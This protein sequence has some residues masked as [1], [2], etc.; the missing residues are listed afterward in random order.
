[1]ALLACSS[2]SPL[3]HQESPTPFR[4]CFGT[5][6]PSTGERLG[7]G[8]LLSLSLSL[9]KKPSNP[10]SLPSAGRLLAGSVDDLNFDPS[11]PVLRGL[12]I[13]A[14]KVAGAKL[15]AIVEG[16]RL[17]CRRPTDRR[18]ASRHAARLS[19]DLME[20][21]QTAAAATVEF[22]RHGLRL[23]ISRASGPCAKRGW[24]GRTR[25]VSAWVCRLSLMGTRRVDDLADAATDGAERRRSGVRGGLTMSPPSTRSP[26]SESQASAPTDLTESITAIPN[27]AVDRD[28]TPSLSHR[29]VSAR[30]SPGGGL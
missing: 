3:C 13:R 24:P 5:C 12:V 14:P 25:A 15:I 30:E 26:R 1:M 20:C 21:P 17:V 27:R 2:V 18:A 29:G 8:C 22:V 19:V 23:A 7:A 28:D 11:K 10:S 16:N 9:E 4:Q 6:P